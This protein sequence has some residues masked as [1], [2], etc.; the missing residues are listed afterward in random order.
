M[1]AGVELLNDLMGGL[2]PRRLLP[3]ARGGG[4]YEELA[5]DCVRWWRGSRSRTS[6]CVRLVEVSRPDVEGA[7]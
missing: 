4:T 7:L 1:L 3:P 2:L 6:G 5:V